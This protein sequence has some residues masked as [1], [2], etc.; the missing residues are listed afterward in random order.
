[1][2]HW[3]STYN[4]QGEYADQILYI[5]SVWMTKLSITFLFIRLSP[6][7]GHVLAA[8]VDTALVA[9]TAVVAILVVAL[10]CNIPHPW[11]HINAH[12]AQCPG[13]VSKAGLPH[14]D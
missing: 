8:K 14:V 1:M 3:Q 10:R 5:C 9:I 2:K 4:G 7:R 6:K 12:D 13:L 11:I